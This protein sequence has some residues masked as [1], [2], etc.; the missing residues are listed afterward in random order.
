M[1]HLKY[2]KGNL[3]VVVGL[4]LASL[5]FYLTLHAENQS[6]YRNEALIS[7]LRIQVDSYLYALDLY[8]STYCS[9]DGVID[10]SDIFP[11]FTS[12]HWL[13]P[14]NSN[15]S[16]SIDGNTGKRSISVTFSDSSYYDHIAN[17]NWIDIVVDKDPSTKKITFTHG[18]ETAPSQGRS[19]YNRSLFI[20][21]SPNGC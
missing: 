19:N 1:N 6:K 7:A 20:S 2:Q 10:E 3:L 21:A 12:S 13:S 8:G 17:I 4:A 18:R 9:A 16:F 11:A 15:T 5:S 14:Y